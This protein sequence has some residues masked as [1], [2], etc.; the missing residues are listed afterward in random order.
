MICEMLHVKREFVNCCLCSQFRR[1]YLI[2][3]VF[4]KFVV[5]VVVWLRYIYIYY[6]F[7]S[8][9]NLNMSTSS[10]PIR[11]SE[12]L[13]GDC[14]FHCL[15][16]SNEMGK[17]GTKWRTVTNRFLP[18]KCI[19]NKERALHWY[20]FKIAQKMSH[21]KVKIV[22]VRFHLL[23]WCFQQTPFSTLTKWCW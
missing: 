3:F 22:D 13:W 11:E 6:F 8:L 9:F 14:K 7:I 12:H 21:F 18:P 2:L 5:I 20:R 23:T 17:Y 19:H 4:R 16:E 15:F 10:G 1:I